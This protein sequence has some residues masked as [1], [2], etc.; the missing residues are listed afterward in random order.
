MLDDYHLIDSQ[1][2]HDGMSFFIENMPSQIHLV[3][4][5]REDPLLPIT[6]LRVRDQLTELRAAD[7]RFSTAEATEFLNRVMGLSL[8][9]EDVAALEGRT[10]GWIA[11]LQ[12]AAI[13]LQGHTDIS[14]LIQSF[15]GSNRFV[16][17]YLID[18]VLTQ[19]TEIVQSFLLQTSILDQLTGSLCDA[20]TGQEHGQA[21]LEMLERANLFIIPLDNERCWYRYHHLFADLLHQRLHQTQ[22]DHDEILHNRASAWY[23]HHEMLDEAIEHTFRA[24]DFKR[25]AD[26]I[27]RLADDLWKHGEHPKLRGW[28]EKLAEDWGC[29]QPKLCIYHAWFLFST[30]REQE[31]ETYLQAAERALAVIP[32]ELAD[33]STHPEPAADA[34]QTQV[35]GRL[36]AI[37]ALAI[38]WGEDFPAMIQYAQ[39]A[40]AL[41]PKGDPWERMAELV[42]GDAYFYQGDMEASYQ[43]RIKTLAD[44]REDDDLFFYMIANLKVAHS[45]CEMGRLVEAMDICREQL[46]F[47]RQNGLMQTIFA[48]WAM[49]IL[50]VT[51]AERNELE[52]TLG[53]T[54]KYV[55]LTQGND[56]GFVSSSYMSLAKVQYYH[57]DIETAVKYTEYVGRYWPK[58]L[59]AAL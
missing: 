42:L 2:I 41:L 1:S 17:D 56:L 5:T 19:Q 14:R 3:V 37:R 15:T 30:G 46:E 24:G 11:G 55:E 47:A 28:L 25:A 44:C 13:S 52:E 8:N 12:L 21:I 35:K 6:R 34:D 18:E 20:L 9:A 59:P 10:E 39:S 58:T 43:T 50:S 16:L 45:L 49:G 54:T 36:N 51:L 57:G 7:L 31:A 32:Q 40:L 23:E 33:P 27:V 53:L 48:G 38:S 29:D 4:A 26:L 22:P